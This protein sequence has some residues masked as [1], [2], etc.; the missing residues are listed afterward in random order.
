MP[1]S[2]GLPISALL[3][4]PKALKSQVRVPANR[5]PKKGITDY[6]QL[7][8]GTPSLPFDFHYPSM[9]PRQRSEPSYSR[10]SFDFT[11]PVTSSKD[12]AHVVTEGLNRGSSK[13]MNKSSIAQPQRSFD[14]RQLLDPKGFNPDRPQRD[15]QIKMLDSGPAVL[16]QTNGNSKRDAEELEGQGMGGMIE[17]IHGISHRDERPQKKQKTIRH[18]DD[19]DG[20]KPTF[21]GGGKGGD[22]G[23]YMREKRLEGQAEPVS[24]SEIVD[25]TAGTTKEVLNFPMCSSC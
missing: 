9:E 25:L 17:R 1:V 7:S 2:N 22:V 3:T 8:N 24:T 20:K 12:D 15:K 11:Y 4:D 13:T 19:E 16:P 23:E 6:R 18:D 14:A 10:S 21:T 5:L